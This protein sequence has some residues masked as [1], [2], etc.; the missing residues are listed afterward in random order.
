LIERMRALGIASAEDYERRMSG[1]DNHLMLKD[2]A[3][4]WNQI[5]SLTL[6][7]S[8]GKLFN[9]SRYW[10]LP[11]IDVTDREFFKAL[12]SDA[13]LTSFT[14][15]PVRNRANGGWT[16]HLVRKVAG[17]NG[18]FLGLLLGAMDMPYFEQYFGSITMEAGSSVSLFRD[19][20]VLLARYP[21]VDPDL[22]RSYSQNELLMDVLSRTKY[23]GVRQI[24]LI[25]G[26]ERLIAAKRL[27]HYPFVLVATTTLD[28]A[29]A[30]WRK[31]AIEIVGVALLMMVAFC[32]SILL[33]ARQVGINLSKQE[34]RLD[35]ALHNMRQGL[36]MFNADGEL[37]LFNQRYLQ[38]Y[39]LERESVKPGCTL[40]DLLRLR[41][42]VGTFTGDP[43]QYVAKFVDDAGKFRGDPDIATFAG[44]GTET[45]AIE[46]ADGRCVSIT[47]QSMEGGGWVSTHSDITEQRGA[48]QE[49]GRTRSFLDTV[50][51]NV[52]ASLI[53][54]NA[55][56][57]RYVLINRA[58]EQLL[59][60]PREELIG[61]TAYDF[62]P[63]EVADSINAL[64][65][66]LANGSE[67]LVDEHPIRTPR[68]GI[69]LLSTK[70]LA[71]L[72][73]SGRPRYLLR[74]IED[75]T[76]RKRAEARIEHMARHDALTDLPNR[77]A[78]TEHLEVTLQHAAA[79]QENFAVICLDLDRFKEVND[80]FGHSVGDMLLCEVAR[81][82]QRAIQGVFIARV[83]GDEFTVII[84]GPQPA[85]A[86][87][88]ADTLIA[89]GE[90]EFLIEGHPLR[91]G[92]TIGVAIFPA[93]GAD[94]TTLL[95]NADAAL[96]R[97]KAEARGSIRFFEA[98][99]DQRLRERRALQQDLRSAAGCGELELYYQPQALIGGEVVGFEAL[100]RWNHPSRG[101]V[102]PGTFV[103]IAEESGLIVAI[104]EWVLR[105]A[106]REA[107]SW[108]QPLGIAI[109]LSPVQFQHG[110]LPGLLHSI[111]L[112]TGLAPGRLELEITENVLI[113][114]FSRAV[115]ILRRLKLLGVRIAM[116]DFGTGYSSLS[117]LQSFPFDKIKIDQTF[118]SNLE[119]HPQSATI[120]RAVIGLGRGL[121]VPIL[122][123]GVETKEQL[124]F[125]TR[126]ACGEVQGYLIGV[127]LPIAD[128]AEMVG[129]LP[130]A[131]GKLA[132]ASDR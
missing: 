83:G 109:N 38:M 58:G 119:H 8:R 61:K 67:M 4:G 65:E 93:D 97:A 66:N 99:M 129:R 88:L 77:A 103:P 17:A 12:K 25:E 60:V 122:A 51:E 64:D 132:A 73:D 70:R 48:E 34:V 54:K 104:G 95:G 10:P 101:L 47:N 84:D 80:I 18:E 52:P 41:K 56:D 55:D 115:S 5:G 82:L 76:E 24:G 46:L 27:D 59:G 69:R 89:V 123:E 11:D 2:K 7:N 108:P 39:G 75:V 57:R 13:N 127:P 81:R 92:V 9:F 86:E 53:V 1:Y 45:K 15:E 33:C 62:Y 72:G 28:A 43:D 96:Y 21:S 100:L 29:L 74:V 44:E 14:G 19:D 23:A 40:A 32:A 90:K 22:A 71:I 106:C 20:G 111:L 26:K 37:V 42:A 78:F 94:A 91:V 130:A 31:N 49:L 87:A 6:I 98:Q 128:Y 118:I 131:P 113:G 126:E 120:I 50:V 107:A 112:E 35:A 16:I 110:D 30:D 121:D 116:D 68:K 114:D 117:Y 124:E 105:E 102:L 3:S 85:T 63:K 36:L 79:A 125:L